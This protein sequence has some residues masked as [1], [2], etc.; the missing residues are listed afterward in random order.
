MILKLLLIAAVVY[1]VY[2]IFFKKRKHVT[3]EST[4]P[5]PKRKKVETNEMVECHECALYIEISEAI[6]SN[7]HYYC[8]KE[9]VAKGEK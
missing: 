9:C 7:G 8:S 3:Q 4:S 6:L 5:K 2:L 1:G